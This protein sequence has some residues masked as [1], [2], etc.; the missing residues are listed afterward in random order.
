MLSIFRNGIPDTLPLGMGLYLD[1]GD[2][3]YSGVYGSEVERTRRTMN[4][5][6][7]LPEDLVGK[8]FCCYNCAIRRERSELRVC[9]TLLARLDLIS[10]GRVLDCAWVIAGLEVHSDD[11]EL[12]Y[13]DR[14]ERADLSSL[15]RALSMP[16]RGIVRFGE[17]RDDGVNGSG[18]PT[19]CTMDT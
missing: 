16:R 10:N 3:K 19:A 5:W 17:L 14:A 6:V 13:A 2:G 1:M 18:D 8:R 11:P 4:E 9:E 7:L 15:V 12:P